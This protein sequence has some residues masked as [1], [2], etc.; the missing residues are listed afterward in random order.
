M[1]F[2]KKLIF[3]FIAEFDEINI[4]LKFIQKIRSW[5]DSVDLAMVFN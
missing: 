4:Y 1:H 5:N 2:F 3:N